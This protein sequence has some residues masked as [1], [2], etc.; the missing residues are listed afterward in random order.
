MILH[1]QVKVNYRVG[2]KISVKLSHIQINNAC[3]LDGYVK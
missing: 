3:Q 2:L 1:Q